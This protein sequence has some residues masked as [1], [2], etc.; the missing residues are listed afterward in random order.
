MGQQ[1]LVEEIDEE[2]SEISR[3]RDILNQLKE[4]Q[5]AEEDSSVSE[6]THAEESEEEELLRL[7]E[8]R[9][10]LLMMNRD[11]Q[12]KNEALSLSI[13]DER[14]AVVDARS[15]LRCLYYRH[16]SVVS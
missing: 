1:E 4:A 3:L 5:I 7:V 8:L 14:E 16:I 12:R 6:Q 15:R 2:E 10:D 9:N 11:I 13:H